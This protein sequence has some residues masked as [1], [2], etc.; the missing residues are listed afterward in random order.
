[1][2]HETLT[3]IHLLPWS[4]CIMFKWGATASYTSVKHYMKGTSSDTVSFRK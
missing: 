4:F 3:N 2:V 1:M